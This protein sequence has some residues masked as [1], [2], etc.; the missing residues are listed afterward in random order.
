VTAVLGFGLLAAAAPTPAAGQSDAR[1]AFTSGS[2]ATATVSVHFNFNITTTGFPAA[3]LTQTGIIPQGLVFT[4]NANADG[5]ATL[6]GTPV[7][8]DGGTYKITLTAANAAGST[9]QTF[10]LT[11]DQAPVITSGAGAVALVG[12]RLKFIVRTT[13]FPTATVSESG[14]LPQGL[15]FNPEAHGKA[16]ISG[17]PAAGTGGTYDI[18]LTA[19]NGITPPATQSFVLTFDQ[20]PAI[21]SASSA[22]ITSPNSSFLFTVYTTGVPTPKLAES[23]TLPAGLA[24][25]AYANGTATIS[26]TPSAATPGKYKISLKATNVAGSATQGFVLTVDS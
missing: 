8:G 26:G 11:V 7:Q 15:G 4:P 6:S 5:D 22:T 1:P 23:G 16:T 14:A 3:T 10:M 17:T 2:S 25:T 19:S 12:K 9:N 21:T 13:G 24:F 18:T 20:R